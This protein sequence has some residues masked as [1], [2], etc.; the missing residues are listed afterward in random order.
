VNAQAAPIEVLELC[1]QCRLNVRYAIARP[2]QQV[3]NVTRAAGFLFAFCPHRHTHLAIDSA[4]ACVYRR[5][6]SLELAQHLSGAY[7]ASADYTRRH[8]EALTAAA[9]AI[10]NDTTRAGQAN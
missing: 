6:E 10:A 8:I 3:R 4:G 5:A 7:I 2:Q 1:R 9:V